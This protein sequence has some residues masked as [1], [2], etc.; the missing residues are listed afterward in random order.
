MDCLFPHKDHVS[1]NELLAE[2]AGRTCYYSF[3]LKAGRKSNKDYLAH[4]QDGEVPHRSIFYHAKMTFFLAGVSRRLSHEMIRNY[5][6]A[7][8]TEEGAPSQESTRYVENAGEYIAHPGLIYDDVPLSHYIQQCHDNYNSY[9]SFID[10]REERYRRENNGKS[11]TGMDRKRIFETA[12]SLLEH[13]VSTSFVWTTNPI[14][15]AKLI[16]ERQHESADLEFQ[17]LAKIWKLEAV[18]RWP[19]L[20]PQPWMK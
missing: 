8:R 16:Q 4:T 15:L 10:F 2:L 3:G 17:R 19:N 13:S 20:F 14:A 18:T 11:P 12:S 5:V 9:R 1:H 6:G 7:D